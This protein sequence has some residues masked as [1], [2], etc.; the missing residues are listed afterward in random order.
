MKYAFIIINQ[1]TRNGY[2]LI[3][4]NATHIGVW[5]SKVLVPQRDDNWI[6]FSDNISTLDIPTINFRD[7]N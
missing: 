4:C 5:I 3:W 1:E 7:P 2:L 6:V